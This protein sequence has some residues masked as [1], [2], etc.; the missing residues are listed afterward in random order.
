MSTPI[1]RAIGRAP[2]VTR[3]DFALDRA[4]AACSPH[5]LG[6]LACGETTLDSGS[7]NAR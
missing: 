4:A 1:R 6:R 7:G 5:L 2:I 3:R